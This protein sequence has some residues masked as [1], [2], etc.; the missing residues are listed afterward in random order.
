MSYENID[1]AIFGCLHQIALSHCMVST[2]KQH[3]CCGMCLILMC[4]NWSMGVSRYVLSFRNHAIADYLQ[5]QGYGQTLESFKKE[6]EMVRCLLP[7]PLN[8]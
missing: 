2:S 1:I 3:A 5:S 8:M 6:A 7:P 4:N